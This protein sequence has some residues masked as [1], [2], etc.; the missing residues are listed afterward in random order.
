MRSKASVDG[1]PIHPGLIPFP[2]A[3]LCGALGFDLAGRVLERPAWWATG[4]HL[5][6]A[7]LITGLAAAIPGFID[8]AYSVPPRSSG[9]RRATSHMLLALGMMVLFLVA[10]VLRRGAIV[11]PTIA[12]LAIEGAGA[13]LLA[14]AGSMGGTLVTRN[15]ISVDHRFAGRRR[16]SEATIAPDQDGTLAGAASTELGVD[17]MKLLHAGGK[18]IVLA[19]TAAGYTAFDDACAHEGG[20]LAGGTMICGTVQC[21]WHGSQFDSRTGQV[22]AGPAEHAIAVY[23]VEERDGVVR[24]RIA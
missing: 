7:G 22:R 15:Q 10:V 16:W 2:F 23:Q 12:V 11:E 20:S 17:Q 6:V 9:R 14:A 18:R 5:A 24:I 21:P 19:R 1:H 3:F 13:A 8:Y 4:Y